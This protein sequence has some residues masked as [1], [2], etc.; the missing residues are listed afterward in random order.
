MIGLAVAFVLIV[1]TV[2][3]LNLLF[4]KGTLLGYQVRD[5]APES[6]ESTEFKPSEA[7]NKAPEQKVSEILGSKVKR[8]GGS[9]ADRKEPT[10]ISA[11]LYRTEQNPIRSVT[12]VIRDERNEYAAQKQQEVLSK[13]TKTES[14]EGIGDQAFYFLVSQQLNVRTGKQLITV[15]VSKPSE[16]SKISP[17]DAAVQIAKEVL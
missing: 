2:S 3:Q 1:L 14:V 7:C 6:S 15:T 12:I 10:F 9:F 16:D 17:K 8:I 13:R 11:C 4:N 5:V